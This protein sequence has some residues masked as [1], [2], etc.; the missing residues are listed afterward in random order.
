[1]MIMQN[2]ATSL[3]LYQKVYHT[4]HEFN[5]TKYTKYSKTTELCTLNG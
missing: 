4:T 2:D 1:M 5:I 3:E